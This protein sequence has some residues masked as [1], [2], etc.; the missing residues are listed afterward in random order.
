MVADKLMPSVRY[1]FTK[2]KLALSKHFYKQFYKHFHPISRVTIASL[3]KLLNL[4]P[5][6]SIFNLSYE[7]FNTIVVC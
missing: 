3:D 7:A 2:N 6:G 5:K 1:F 4:V